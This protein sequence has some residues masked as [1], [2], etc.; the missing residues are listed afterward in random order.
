MKHSIIK[1]VVVIGVSGHLIDV[2]VDIGEGLPGF[3]IVGLADTAVAE[4]RD[5][6]KLEDVGNCVRRLQAVPSQEA[7][8]GDVAS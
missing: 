6:V 3:S 2:E 1:S 5:R 7:Q 4:A 8:A